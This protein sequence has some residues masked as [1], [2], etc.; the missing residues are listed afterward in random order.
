MALFYRHIF[1]FNPVIKMTSVR[2][3]VSANRVL[4]LTE[5]LANTWIFVQEMSCF[6]ASFHSFGM[7]NQTD[8]H[9]F[10]ILNL[11]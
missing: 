5:N 11:D 6:H 2:I 10:F 3:N 8:S 1:R 7:H 9:S 4:L